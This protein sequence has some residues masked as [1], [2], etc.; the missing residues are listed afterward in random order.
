MFRLGALLRRLSGN[1]ADSLFEEYYSAVVS[2]AGSGA[3]SAREARRDF[4]AVRRV[5][6]RTVWY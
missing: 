3:P 2:R 1:S 6:T 5:L 4:E